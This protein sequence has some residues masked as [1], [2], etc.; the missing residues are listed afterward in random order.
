MGGSTTGSS[1]P[2]KAVGEGVSWEVEGELNSPSSDGVSVD[3]AQ[4]VSRNPLPIRMDNMIARR[5]RC[6]IGRL[7]DRWKY[8]WIEAKTATEVAGTKDL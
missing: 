2:G 1:R 6:R 4:A 8:F 5:I 7:L 3:R